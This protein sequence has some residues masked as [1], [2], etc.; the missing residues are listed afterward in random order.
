M[1]QIYFEKIQIWQ[2]DMYPDVDPSYRICVWI[3]RSS[4]QIFPT[5]AGNPKVQ[6]VPGK[7]RQVD[8]LHPAQEDQALLRDL[9]VPRPFLVCGKVC[10]RVGCP[11][12][13]G[14]PRQ[15]GAV[16]LPQ[17]QHPLPG[18]QFNRVGTFFWPLLGTFFALLNWD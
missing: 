9:Q 18:W 17:M 1:I 8:Y 5:T 11:R 13:A 7:V 15:R 3:F 4:N 14:T 10:P 2:K 6:L 12:S 16:Q